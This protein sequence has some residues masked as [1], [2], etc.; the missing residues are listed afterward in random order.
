[1]SLPIRLAELG[2]LP[3][4]AIR[5]GIRRLLGRRLTECR[6][7]G[8]SP[9]APEHR[10]IAVATE[11]ANEQHYEVDPEFFEIVLGARRKY[12]CCWYDTP[13]AA[14]DSAEEAMLQLTC[15]RAGLADGM[16]I[17]ELGCG[18]GSLTLWMA[19]HYPNSRITA[20]S[21]SAP[22]RKTIE[23]LAADRGL[24]N[25][26][27]KTADINQYRPDD[28]YDR[29]VSVEMFEHVRNHVLLLERIARWLK[30]GGRLF[31]HIFCHDTYAYDYEDRGDSDWM[32]RHFF[33]GGMMP[34]FRYFESLPVPFSVEES[35]AVNGEHYARTCRDWL[36]NLDAH[37]DAVVAV[38]RKTLSPAE[39]RVQAQ[40]WR[41][42]FMA[43]EE[44]FA[45]RGGREWYVGHYLMAPAE[46]DSEAHPVL[47]VEAAR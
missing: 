43:C 3:D 9:G 46:T 8:E 15:E 7:A 28:L 18:W 24:G 34:S 32:A 40:R 17:L 16:D 45:Y 26:T 39:A 2:W 42:F 31:V 44:L 5:F 6:A 23:A 41:I 1:M 21:N 20:V 12:S 36:R 14:L 35:W 11:R 4:A 37:R 13:D 25:V 38:L 30:P 10:P 19:E 29:I 27:V 33:S 22:Q 47:E